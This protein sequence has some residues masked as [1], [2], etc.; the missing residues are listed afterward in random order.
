MNREEIRSRI[1]EVGILPAIRASSAEDAEF[2]ATTVARAGIPLAEITV[3][4]PHAETVITKLRRTV[5]EILVGAGT[6][7]DV[8][9]ARRC[10]DAG[11]EFLTSP[12]FVAEVGRS[13]R[14]H[15]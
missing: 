3:T 7:L 2:A 1:E 8:E 9:M 13:Q 6:V 5:P 14:S 12:G 10:L 15:K 11:A 4:V